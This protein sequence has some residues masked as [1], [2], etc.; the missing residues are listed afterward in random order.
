M[1][2][3]GKSTT[4]IR[5]SVRLRNAGLVVAAVVC[6]AAVCTR[7]VRRLLRGGKNKEVLKRPAEEKAL[8]EAKPAP[9]PLRS[10][11]K[12]PNYVPR[13]LRVRFEGVKS[14]WVA[15]SV[16]RKR[17]EQRRLATEKWNS[18]GSSSPQAAEVTP[19]ESSEIMINSDTKGS[20]ETL[21]VKR[22]DI[23][24]AASQHPASCPI[25]TPEDQGLER[26][27]SILSAVSI[28]PLEVSLDNIDTSVDASCE[29]DANSIGA[30][31]IDIV[32]DSFETP[33]P[34]LLA[35]SPR[36]RRAHLG[37]EEIKADNN[38]FQLS[39]A[40]E[41]RKKIGLKNARLS[42]QPAETKKEGEG[43]EE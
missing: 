1:G 8:G 5:R 26:T 20:D 10:C 25:A 16:R 33:S 4:E 31:S 17:E 14:A 40:A 23:R 41:R 24:S 2:C 35:V 19:C 42:P 36:K 34:W 39:T 29:A 32:A 27:E 18:P 30:E 12:T 3:N 21:K 15:P 13:N 6:T 22:G 28:E 43:V 7:G 9:K 37:R 11:L 38:R